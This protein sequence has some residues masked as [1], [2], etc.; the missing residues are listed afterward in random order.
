MKNAP[1]LLSLLFL[2]ILVQRVAS[3]VSDP[4]GAG[5]LMGWTFALAIS[6]CVFLSAYWLKS[7]DKG[8]KLAA[9][10][11]LVL[12]A[13]ADFI[14]NGIEVYRHLDA[15]GAW[16]KPALQWAGVVYAAMPTVASMALGFLQG[17]IGRLPRNA[18]PKL[19]S[20]SVARLLRLAELRIAQRLRATPQRNTQP[21]NATL[22]AP[23]P[24]PATRNASTQR[25]ATD[26]AT[27]F[28]E[29]LAKHPDITPTQ[30][31]Q[32]TGANKSTA[33]RWLS[34]NRNG[35]NSIPEKER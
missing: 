22:P 5:L 10:I 27:K 12:F 18:T 6:A 34:A 13:L 8:V 14:L 25:N 9:T 28:T 26:Y 3:L 35:H 7:K 16:D 4:L 33:S 11:S 21:P 24:K 30:L 15:T 20:E 29:L 2:A 31:S 32:R 23:A 17:R 1:T 19:W